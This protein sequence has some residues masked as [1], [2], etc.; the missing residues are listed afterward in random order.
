MRSKKIIASILTATIFTTILTSCSNG[1]VSNGKRQLTLFS[2]KIEAVDTYNGLIEEFEKENPDIEV[3][4]TAPPDA[5][6]VLKSRFIKEDSPDII[7]LSADRV[8]ADFVEANILEDLTGK[9]DLTGIDDIYNKML[10]DL[11][12]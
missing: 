1:N 12:I 10:K 9:V 3:V 8:Y 11:E 5:T 4:L 2:N 7:Q 6:T